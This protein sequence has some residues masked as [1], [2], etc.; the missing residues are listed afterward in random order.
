MVEPTKP[1]SSHYVLELFETLYH[2]YNKCCYY[3]TYLVIGL[4]LIHEY[5]F[6]LS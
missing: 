4:Q 1:C 5:Y 2:K 3:E 6:N